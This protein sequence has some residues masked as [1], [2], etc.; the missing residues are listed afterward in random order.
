MFEGAIFIAIDINYGVFD[1]IPDFIGY[2]I[3]LNGLTMLYKE[4]SIKKFGI[5]NYF[6]IL[7]LTESIVNIFFPINISHQNISNVLIISMVISKLI[8]LFF[9]YYIYS[10]SIELL[11]QH[12][13]YE[14]KG[15]IETARTIYAFTFIVITLVQIF[16]PNID[17]NIINS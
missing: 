16:S 10:D 15:T 9:V 5:A 1:I 13:E 14:L 17:I 3:M 6:G 7:L 8:F 12:N 2:I 4:T 11:E